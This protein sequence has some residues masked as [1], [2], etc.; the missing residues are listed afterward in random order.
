[1]KRIPLESDRPIDAE[2]HRLACRVVNAAASARLPVLLFNAESVHADGVAVFRS[3]HAARLA[4]DGIAGQWRALGLGPALVANPWPID[5]PAS[6]R[7][8]VVRIAT[9]NRPALVVGD[10]ERLPDL[11]P[12]EPDDARIARELIRDLLDAIADAGRS[13][14]DNPSA[15]PGPDLARIV[16]LGY[17]L[18]TGLA[19]LGVNLDDP[20]D[21]AGAGWWRLGRRGGDS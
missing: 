13:L 9:P 12:G 6:G 19:D 2:A 16:L 18:A 17:G 7:A 21:A 3:E 14:L 20:P 15:D 5:L 8:F 10:P 11:V 1:M 4:C